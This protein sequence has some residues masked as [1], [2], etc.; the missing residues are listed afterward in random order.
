M[1]NV[2][3]WDAVWLTTLAGGQSIPFILTG[4]P[5]GTEIGLTC[6]P[7]GQG[8]SVLAVEN[9]RVDENQAVFFDAVNVGPSNSEVDGINLAFSFISQ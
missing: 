7:V 9:F 4:V 1:A 8:G 3:Y 6:W 2:Q 5:F